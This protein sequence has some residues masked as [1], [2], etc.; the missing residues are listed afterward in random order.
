[1]TTGGQT[2]KNLGTFE[3]FLAEQREAS[4]LAA[5]GAMTTTTMVRPI[6]L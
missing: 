3:A 2:S 6:R 5:A 1:M 4:R